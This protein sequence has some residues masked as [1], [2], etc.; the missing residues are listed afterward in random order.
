MTA[1]YLECIGG[2]AGDML[3]GALVDAGLSL[4]ALRAELARLPVGGYSLS[5]HRVRRGGLLATKVTV[6]VE[7]PQGPRSLAEVLGIVRASSLPEGDKE[8]VERVFRLLGE[9]EARA[10]GQGVEEVHLHEA[11]A[12]DALVDVVGTVA[13]LRLLGVQALYCSPLPLPAGGPGRLAPATAQVLAQ[14]GAPVSYVSGPAHE[15]VTPTGAALVGGLATFRS[16]TLRVR[17]VAYGAGEVDFAD[18]PNVV[19]L[20]LGEEAAGGP[21]V[22]LET[23]LDDMTPE[24]LAYVQERLLSS[25]ALDVWAVPAQMKKGRPGVVLSVLCPAEMEGEIVAFLLRETTTLGVRRRPVER[26]E[27]PREVVRFE[28]SLGPAAVKVRRGPWG[29]PLVAPEFED[30][31]RLAQERGLPIWEVYRRLE[32]EARAFLGLG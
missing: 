13:G 31:R 29:P 18:R 16:P 23:N 4:E 14:A 9:A 19:R 3:L 8:R 11:G 6:Q 27:A 21:L 7:A 2:V 26:W 28:S 5:A 1:A 12:V 25:G 15:M 32:A 17:A 24:A 30:C 22:L 20:W 10:H